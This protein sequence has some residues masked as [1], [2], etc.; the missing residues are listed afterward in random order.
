MRLRARPLSATACLARALRF[1]DLVGRLKAGISQKRSRQELRA[2]AA[3]LAEKYPGANRG[4][5]FDVQPP[6]AQVTGRFRVAMF[7]L[8][9][10]PA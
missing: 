3:A 4:F 8:L 10:R 7:L 1:L 2:M 6:R 9:G 5:A